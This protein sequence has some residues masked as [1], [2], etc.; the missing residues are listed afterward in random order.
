[1]TAPCA[2][3][4]ARACKCAHGRGSRER[5]PS[6]SRRRIP[7]RHDGTARAP[8]NFQWPCPRRPASRFGAGRR[9]RWNPPKGDLLMGEARTKLREWHV[10]DSAASSL[11]YKTRQ[12]Q[13]VV[14]SPAGCSLQ[15]CSQ[16]NTTN[17]SGSDGGAMKLY[18]LRNDFPWLG[19][20]PPCP[21]Q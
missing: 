2:R 9:A 3:A 7:G 14:C 15:A 5:R 1:L 20:A 16:P 19:T 18:A 10:R 21:P 13:P 6:R 4:R 17:V 8:A 12:L 11:I